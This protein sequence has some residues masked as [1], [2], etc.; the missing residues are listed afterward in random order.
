MRKK[1][2]ATREQ[3]WYQLELICICIML[4]MNGYI[5]GAVEEFSIQLSLTLKKANEIV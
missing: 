5:S 1:A 4:R 3:N 2:K